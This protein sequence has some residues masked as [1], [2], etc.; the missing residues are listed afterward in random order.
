M[1]I[2]PMLLQGSAT[3]AVILES[4]LTTLLIRAM[5]QQGAGLPNPSPRKDRPINTD[6]AA[7]ANLSARRKP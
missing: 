1:A 7:K 6:N 4:I 5:R 3:C 2:L